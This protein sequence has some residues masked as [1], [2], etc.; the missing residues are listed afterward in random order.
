MHATVE[1]K[2][3]NVAPTLSILLHASSLHSSSIRLSVTKFKEIVSV[4]KPIPTSC[5]L[6]ANVIFGWFQEISQIV[7]FTYL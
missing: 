2:P 3:I 1:Y 7:P 6:A 5:G 4:D